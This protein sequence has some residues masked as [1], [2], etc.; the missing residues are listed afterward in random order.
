MGKKTIM[1]FAV[2]GLGFGPAPDHPGGGRFNSSGCFFRCPGLFPS[3]SA[4]L[5]NETGVPRDEEDH[6]QATT[7]G[8]T[9]VAKS[10]KQSC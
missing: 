4:Q 6:T 3:S 1:R 9:Q 7:A 2:L 5:E 8:S 10:I